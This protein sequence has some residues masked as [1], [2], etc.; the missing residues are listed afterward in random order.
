MSETFIGVRWAVSSIPSESSRPLRNLTP[1]VVLLLGLLAGYLL[2]ERVLV[3]PVRIQPS[4]SARP[5]RYE[6]AD[7][8]THPGVAPASSKG[9]TAAKASTESVR[10]SEL[11]RALAAIPVRAEADASGTISVRALDSTESPVANIQ[12][13]LRPVG[14]PPGAQPID[15]VENDLEEYVRRRVD[16]QRYHDAL[17]QSQVTGVDGLCTFSGVADGVYRVVPEGSGYQFDV[18]VDQSSGRLATPGCSVTIQV[19]PASELRVAVSLPD[20]TP[21]L[22]ATIE[23][24]SGTRQQNM[25]W[26]QANPT[27]QIQ[28]GRYELVARLGDRYESEPQTVSVDADRAPPTVALQL[29]PA[30]VLK[31]EVDSSEAPNGL[32]VTIVW[33]EAEGELDPFLLATDAYRAELS[34][35]RGVATHLVRDLVPGT[36]WVGACYNPGRVDVS[37]VVELG[38][39]LQTLRLSL[40]PVSTQ[41]QLRFVVLDSNGLPLENVEVTLRL[42]EYDHQRCRQFRDSSGAI[43]VIANPDVQRYRASGD[44]RPLQAMVEVPSLGTRVVDVTS[45]ETVV[46]FGPQGRLEVEVLGIDR[47]DWDSIHLYLRAVSDVNEPNSSYLSAL[48]ENAVTT[49]GTPRFVATAEA[50]DYNL[51]GQL[52]QLHRMTPQRVRLGAG[53]QTLVVSMPATH[54]FVLQL[55]PGTEEHSVYLMS[56][57]QS[58]ASGPT[59]VEGQLA[60][61]ENVPAGEYFVSVNEEFMR[62]RVDGA[63]QAAFVPLQLNALEVAIV[64]ADLADIYGLR[65]GDLIVAVAGQAFEGSEQVQL[66]FARFGGGEPIELEL[67]RSGER[68][69]LILDAE[70]TQTLEQKFSSGQ[71]TLLPATQ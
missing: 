52:S 17:R 28:P 13:T 42:G 40:P 47:T 69:P 70:Q 14:L 71:L 11:A 48:P 54:R 36:Y 29:R 19:V 2:S 62:L 12:V 43:V 1:F 41:E 53:T 59:R 34:M 20:G 8:A 66:A 18:R 44:A 60:I 25:T 35:Q 9:G 33:R 45:A 37:A 22:N 16:E 15:L 56:V 26:T 24:R 6:T 30:R 61:F 38:S 55:P 58:G 68:I 49:S 50:G 21:S 27:L 31:I 23:V 67:L 7:P 51:E 65:D 5:N 63:Q 4:G 57:D 3:D 10:E 39:E 32:S 46:R 64:D